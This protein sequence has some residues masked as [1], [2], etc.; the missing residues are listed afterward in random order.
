M[1]EGRLFEMNGL[2]LFFLIHLLWLFAK[3]PKVI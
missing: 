2:N 1:E 3:L